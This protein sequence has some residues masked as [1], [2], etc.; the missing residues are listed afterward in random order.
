MAVLLTLCLT[1]LLYLR[2]FS[3]CAE[4]VKNPHSDG[5]F[6][7]GRGCGAS[8]PFKSLNYIPDSL[9]DYECSFINLQTF[10]PN[11][12]HI[13]SEVPNCSINDHVNNLIG[14][15]GWNV[16]GWDFISINRYS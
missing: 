16:D 8:N 2:I 3:N 11:Y 5:F 1:I 10:A 15:H 4:L 9:E 6:I 14:N 13:G 12:L 7:T